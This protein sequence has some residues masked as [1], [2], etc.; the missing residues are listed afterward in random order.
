MR[1]L[2]YILII[3]V[4]S[5]APAFADGGH[6]RGGHSSGHGAGHGGTGRGGG[7]FLP[8]LIGGA[9]VYDLTYPYPNYVQPYPVYAPPP[10]YIQTA[11]VYAQPVPDYAS[12]P[13]VPLWYF[14]T[15][16]N[17]YYP[18]VTSCPSGW[19]AVP[20]TPPR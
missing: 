19:Q 6:G 14:C 3:A 2:L 1:K 12:T 5:T 15:S 11:P 8:A 20:A 4:L 10:V 7:W 13:S 18:Y 9:I 16:S 17:A